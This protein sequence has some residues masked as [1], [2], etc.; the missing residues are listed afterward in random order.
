LLFR[1]AWQ[2]FKTLLSDVTTFLKGIS[3]ITKCPIEEQTI[4]NYPINKRLFSNLAI[5]H[6][7]IFS[8]TKNVTFSYAI[9]IHSYRCFES[10]IGSGI[11]NHSECID[12]PSKILG[13]F[14]KIL[15]GI[16]AKNFDAIRTPT[17][18]YYV[19]NLRKKTRKIQGYLDH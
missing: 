9:F 17:I 7:Y 15:L 14:S 3:R 18:I 11:S 4:Q 6:L 8:V 5:L 10:L 1:L 16:S 13:E 12:L 19:K 2:L